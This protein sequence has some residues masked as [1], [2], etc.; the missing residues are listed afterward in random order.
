MARLAD[1]ALLEGV[2]KRLG[3]TGDYQD[4]TIKGYIQ[5]VKEFMEDAGVDEE[6]MQTTRIIGAVTRGVSDLWS[7]GSGDG[8]FSAY[9]MQRVIQ[10]K[11]AGGEEN[12]GL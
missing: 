5:D 4:D 8:T 11:R 2:K 12:E 10:L 6:I 7:Y 1:D 3:I 9:F